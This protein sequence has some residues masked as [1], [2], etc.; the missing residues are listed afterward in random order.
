MY[1]NV[2]ECTGIYCPG[3]LGQ[4]R[5]MDQVSGL[6]GMVWVLYCLLIPEGVN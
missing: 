1:R 2:Q 5:G 6:H 3:V 4:G